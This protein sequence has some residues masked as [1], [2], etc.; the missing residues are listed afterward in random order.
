MVYFKEV[1]L[2]F[3]TVLKANKENAIV[4][5]QEV[6]DIAQKTG[7]YESKEISQAIRFLHDLGSIQY[8]E[9]NSLKDIV[10]INPQVSGNKF[11]SNHFIRHSFYLSKD[12]NGKVGLSQL[13]HHF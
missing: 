12:I 13:R 1:W 2:N 7:I 10:V 9:T 8:F 11:S 5:Y 6:A 4:S 3:E